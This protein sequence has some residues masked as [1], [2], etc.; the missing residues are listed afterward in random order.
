M[1]QSLHT[2]EGYMYR[3]LLGICRMIIGVLI[4]AC[5]LPYLLYHPKIIKLGGNKCTSS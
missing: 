3:E 2:S 5:I 1:H 4:Y